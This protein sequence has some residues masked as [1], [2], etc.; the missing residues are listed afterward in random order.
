MYLITIGVFLAILFVWQTVH[1]IKCGEKWGE[2]GE[3]EIA[4][5]VTTQSVCDA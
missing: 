2:E 3:R 5:A 1:A 4:H